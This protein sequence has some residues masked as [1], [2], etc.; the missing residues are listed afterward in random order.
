M[1]HKNTLDALSVEISLQKYTKTEVKKVNLGKYTQ[2]FTHT[3]P[4][5]IIKKRERKITL[6]PTQKHIKMKKL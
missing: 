1:W 5:V 4:H 2:H 6:C 3:L